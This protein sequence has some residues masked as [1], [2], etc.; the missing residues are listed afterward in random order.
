MVE[1]MIAGTPF[2]YQTINGTVYHVSD[3]IIA[4]NTWQARKA[5]V[6]F[7]DADRAVVEPREIIRQPSVQII[8]ASSPR[9]TRQSWLKQMGNSLIPLKLAVVAK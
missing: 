2:L 5:I 3:A 8:A 6:A 9:G 7:V 4:I 1:S